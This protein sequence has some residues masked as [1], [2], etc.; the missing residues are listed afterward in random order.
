[1]F[2]CYTDVVYIG[3][4]NPSHVPLSVMMLEAEKAV[5]CEKPLAMSVAGVDKIVKFAQQKNKLLVEVKIY[6]FY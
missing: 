2:V 5:L 4:F 6:F 1:M 3:T